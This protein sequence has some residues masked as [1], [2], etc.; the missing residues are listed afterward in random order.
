MPSQPHSAPLFDVRITDDL[1]ASAADLEY[2][3]VRKISGSGPWTPENTGTGSSLVIED[4]V[5]G[6]DIPAGEQVVIEID[7]RLADTDTNVAGLAFTNSA[8]FIYNQL[9]NQDATALSGDPGVT[10]PMTIV[11]PELTLEKTGPVQ[12]VEGLAATLPRSD[13]H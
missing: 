12:M 13:R 4:P 10:G 9:D 6:I 7:V 11:E 1:I 8:A 5:N 3:A 2:V